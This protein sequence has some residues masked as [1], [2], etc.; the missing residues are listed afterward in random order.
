[1]RREPR[2]SSLQSRLVSGGYGKASRNAQS[3]LVLLVALTA[4]TLALSG[5]GSDQSKPDIENANNGS[6][7]PGDISGATGKSDSGGATGGANAK[8]VTCEAVKQPQPSVAN[9]QKPKEQLNQSK[10]YLATFTT[11]C[12]D[13]TVTLDVKR[14]P[15]TA[16][17][18]AQLVDRGVY[19]M[20]W[21]HRVV[22]DFLIQGG[23]PFGNGT[24]TIGYQVV[25]E[26]NG[27]YKVGSVLMAKGGSDPAGMSSS[28]FFVVIGKSATKL[29]H[30]YAI[31]GRVTAGMNVVQYI[32]GYAN[33]DANG[34]PS[35]AVIVKST[36]LT[37]Q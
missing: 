34:L 19:N 29:P 32:S 35:K 4:L 10:T 28:Q 3:F 1:M 17:S 25:E 21:F 2:H 37:K 15:V 30:D 7:G 26:P 33:N 16:T 36:K 12:G 8:P 13:F 18:F 24:G 9:L 27:K 14:N 31:A 6:I 20:T 5:C 23:D 22:K 11:T